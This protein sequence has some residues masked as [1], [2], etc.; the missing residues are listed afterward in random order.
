MDYFWIFGII[1]I[2]SVVKGITGFG[3]AM[4]S[5]PLLL[6]W[7]SPKVIIPVLIMCNLFASIMIVLQKKE[8]K[9]ITKHFK[10]L[11]AYG[12]VFTILGVTTLKT[13]PSK[14]L[15]VIISVFFIVLSITHLFNLKYSRRLKK[16]TYK[17][18][19]AVC[20]FLTGSISIGG[21]PLA[22]FLNLGE[23]NNQ[24]FREVFSWFNIVSASIALI[25]YFFLG[26][27]TL[28][29]IKLSL[30]FLPI[31]IIGSFFGKRIN[32]H[33]P[34]MKFKKITIIMSLVSS[35]FL[36]INAK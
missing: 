12:G 23:T 13:I 31:L 29:S 4:M 22:L 21:P 33:L 15:I 14:I 18:A 9:L 5:L 3:F 34:S 26:L 7:Y 16:Y 19:G 24:Q 8:Y 25:G 27:L 32:S 11:L 1:I 2:A 17:I 36:L 28:E 30:L 20:G 10:S 6:F 35:F